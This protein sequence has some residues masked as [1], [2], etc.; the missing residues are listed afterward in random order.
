[1]HMVVRAL[2]ALLVLCGAV[3]AQFATGSFGA[4]SGFSSSS[5]ISGAL[6]VPFVLPTTGGVQDVIHF[7][8]PAGDDGCDGTTPTVVSCPSGGHGAWASPNHAMNCGDVIVAA[9]GT[10]AADLSVWGVVS[11]C[12]STTGGI[13][14]TGGIHMAVLL[15]G[16][17]DLSTT[18]GCNVNCATVSPC[19]V[20]GFNPQVGIALTESHW[21]VEGW[22]VTCG[23][24]LATGPGCV[25]LSVNGLAPGCSAGTSIEQAFIN[26]V[27][28]NVGQGFET[29]SCNDVRGPDYD[30]VVGSIFQ[31]AMQWNFN[32]NGGLCSGAVD[33]IAPG[34][35]DAT[36][37]NTHFFMYN[38]FSYNNLELSCDAHFDGEDFLTDTLDFN[39]VIG[40]V[41]WANNTGFF[42]SRN[43]FNYT[44]GGHS[45]NP[46]VIKFYNNTCT[47]NMQR[48]TAFPGGNQGEIL[49]NHN[50]GSLPIPGTLDLFNN[51]IYSAHATNPQL[52]TDVLYAYIS[53]IVATS[54]IGSGFRTGAE[55]IMRGTP[56][57]AQDVIGIGSPPG[58]VS[59]NTSALPNFA[60][61]PDLLAS[62][63][64]APNCA[65]FI[66][67]TQCMGYDASTGTLTTPSIISDL[68]PSCANCGG[69]GFQ[70]ANAKGFQ[71]PSPNCL[72]SGDIVTDFPPFLKGIV[73]LHWD[74]SSITQRH[75][76]V[77]LPC[78]M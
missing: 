20:P 13:D 23:T 10:Y 68:Q 25:G 48:D 50:G 17:I 19:P 24:A 59:G 71:L 51:I 44:Y 2:L 36:T 4:R 39:D 31:N 63:L 40:N 43:C 67:T 76:M 16:G 22:T 30:A 49:I 41:V 73:Y 60:N 64:G 14:R 58:I 42:A 74:G 11:N 35:A 33:I 6:S 66:N 37:G 69:V 9:K 3:H 46:A 18:N 70:V 15:C 5:V 77:T 21:A 57:P 47:E 53:E 1:M 56:S 78:G 62:R 55:N 29:V 32:N 45:V 38:N 26:D 28:F 8:D 12:P 7:M 34:R 75:D 65:G 52:G 72:S 61:V 54:N 27:T